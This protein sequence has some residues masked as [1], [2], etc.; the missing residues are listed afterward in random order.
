MVK[1]IK[2]EHKLTTKM[3]KDH[4]DE[5]YKDM[6]VVN[7]VYRHLG[8]HINI[9]DLKKRVALT[10][11][12]FSQLTQESEYF[13]PY[14][15]FNLNLFRE[16]KKLE[17]LTLTSLILI[18]S[19]NVR[20]KYSQEFNYLNIFFGE[21]TEDMVV[22]TENIPVDVKILDIKTHESKMFE[23]FERVKRYIIF[24]TGEKY[25]YNMNFK[26]KKEKIQEDVEKISKEDSDKN[27]I[28]PEK[29]RGN[30]K[31]VEL[32]LDIDAIFGPLSFKDASNVFKN[33]LKISF[34]LNSNNKIQTKTSLINI[35]GKIVQAKDILSFKIGEITTVAGSIDIFYV[36]PGLKPDMNRNVPFVFLKNM[37]LTISNS[38]VVN[39][40]LNSIHI[41]NESVEFELKHS[42][43]KEFFD[44]LEKETKSV[45]MHQQDFIF[46]ETFGNKKLL[47]TDK[48]DQT[49]VRAKL[50][51]VLNFS[52]F[53]YG[54]IDIAL[55]VFINNKVV[56]Y[57]N[58]LFKNT[59]Y[60]P[61]YKLMYNSN[62]QNMNVK[63]YKLKDAKIE[64]NS[65]SFWK[66]NFYSSLQDILDVVGDSHLPKYSLALLK[67]NLH[68]F[69]ILGK[70]SSVKEYK[71]LCTVINNLKDTD[72]KTWPYR[73]EL[74]ISHFLLNDA[75][76]HL[77]EI[78]KTTQILTYDTTQFLNRAYEN[79]KVFMDLIRN[80]EKM[81][82]EAIFNV[83]IVE[84]ML[85]KGF[86]NG[87]SN[88]NILPVQYHRY[89]RSLWDSS[90]SFKKLELNFNELKN[91]VDMDTKMDTLIKMIKYDKS[92]STRLIDI[93]IDLVKLRTMNCYDA[94]QLII[95]QYVEDMKLKF[96]ITSD[97]K[98][99]NF[100]T[101]NKH[102]IDF[103][104][105]N[106][107]EVVMLDGML[108]RTFGMSNIEK[109]KSMPFRCY[110][111]VYIEE[112]GIDIGNLLREIKN[113]ILTNNID[114]L[115]NLVNSTSKLKLGVKSKLAKIKNVS[116]LSYNTY[117]LDNNNLQARKEYLITAFNNL[118]MTARSSK[119]LAYSRDEEIR[120]VAG[121]NYYCQRFN[122]NNGV[123]AYLEKDTVFGFL[124]VRDANTMK[125]KYHSIASRPD[126]LTSLNNESWSP[127]LFSLDDKLEQLRKAGYNL[128]PELLTAYKELVSIDNTLYNEDIQLNNEDSDKIPHIDTE[129]C[130]IKEVENPAILTNETLKREI[131]RL[132]NIVN[133]LVK[134]VDDLSSKV[135]I[136]DQRNL[137][138]NSDFDGDNFE[139]SFDYEDRS[140]TVPT[141]LHI[142]VEN[143]PC[144]ENL[145]INEDVASLEMNEQLHID[146]SSSNSKNECLNC[147][148]ILRK[149]YS[150]FE[151]NKFKTQSSRYKLFTGSFKPS[152]EEWQNT[153]EDMVSK[154]LLIKD[155]MNMEYYIPRNTFDE[156]ENRLM[157]YYKKLDIKYSKNTTFTANESRKYLFCKKNRP[158]VNEW[159]N[160]LNDLLDRDLL[161]RVDLDGKVPKYILQ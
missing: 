28:I 110:L 3:I 80:G 141:T 77:T 133:D 134:R 39:R 13:I 119:R 53:P 4:S 130:L 153:L 56:F 91:L 76:N 104:D 95:G 50:N 66:I 29:I 92:M 140:V 47:V 124:F 123:W 62:F 74:R 70:N 15:F 146:S 152:K 115:F 60:R 89:I 17:N 143:E 79:C 87:T 23:I 131:D 61:D 16:Q 101:S 22:L 63:S 99:K 46:V 102:P 125:I 105:E 156:S 132:N 44:F 159:L 51:E 43:L 93:F 138:I 107:S 18:T 84:L 75:I 19:A 83:I 113:Y 55:S 118:S 32:E 72:L 54:Q 97:L 57:G 100:L 109:W 40:S 111:S 151:F 73:L 34:N 94:V 25:E 71:K 58:D 161:V 14:N 139:P 48:L 112:S 30:N 42:D 135:E 108:H 41:K 154:N 33:S 149:I 121:R 6:E 86:C 96:K 20:F 64:T 38:G 150:K 12:S 59:I 11:K 147:D 5:V 7:H 37:M 148:K 8:K 52:S 142:D 120:M 129:N 106:I 9:D 128:T 85:T 26:F 21:N 24:S 126:L 81:N 90:L 157:S 68:G 114:I 136:I 122:T 155:S 117:A 36:F 82:F 67:T 144:V 78:V 145:E 137:P 98:G 160:I 45:R 116:G 65:L 31:T 127:E 35:N 69:N 49:T 158:S 103:Q 1:R 27:V 88:M 10:L 2:K